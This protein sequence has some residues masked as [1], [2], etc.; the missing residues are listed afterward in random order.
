MNY[1]PFS[2]WALNNRVV[3]CR[4][5]L[6]DI[7][8]RLNDNPNLLTAFTHSTPKGKEEVAKK[9]TKENSTKLDEGVSDNLEDNL[10]KIT[11]MGAVRVPVPYPISNKGLQWF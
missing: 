3:G 2:S 4:E 10:I 11:K 5:T 1:L 6:L 7:T 9:A 8:G